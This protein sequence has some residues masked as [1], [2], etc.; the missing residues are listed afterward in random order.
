M[1]KTFE[2]DYFDFK[3]TKSSSHKPKLNFF[4]YISK[5]FL[6]RAYQIN[7]NYYLYYL[8]IYFKYDNLI[9]ELKKRLINSNLKYKITI[10]IDNL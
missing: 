9:I 5:C 8:F 3:V 2:K 7:Y 4:T 1:C 6:Y 10:L